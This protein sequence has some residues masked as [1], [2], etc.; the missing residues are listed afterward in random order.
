MQPY[1]RTRSDRERKSAV[2][3]VTATLLAHAALALLLFTS[4]LKYLDPPPPERSLIEIQP[5]DLEE[6][7][8]LIQP[9]TGRQ[10]QA[11]TVDPEREVELV[12][13]AKSPYVSDRPN[14]TQETAPDTHGDVEVPAVTEPQ[15]ELDV[16]ASFPGMQKNPSTATTPHSAA[17]G[18]DTF[19]AGQ[20]DGNTPEG[21]TEGSANAH[22]QGRSLLGTIPKPNYGGQ[23]E[24]KVV[25]EISV[26][27]YGDVKE[28]ILGAGSTI[29]PS[30]E[31]W[32][33]IRKAALKAHFNTKADAPALQKGTITYIF[34]LK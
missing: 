19:K 1:L 34:K 8:A 7:L 26:D 12:Q 21:K 15:P 14:V 27:Q 30:P 11:E 9:K 31:M 5:L 20:P 32:A 24:G 13:E 22:L 23:A 33:E 6:E 28:A 25:V 18:S 2:T 10:P 16:R 17:E 29:N 3:G 4:G